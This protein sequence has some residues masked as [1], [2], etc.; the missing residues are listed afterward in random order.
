MMKN[1][2]TMNTTKSVHYSTVHALGV[3]T[4][5]EAEG[6]TEEG[7]SDRTGDGITINIVWQKKNNNNNNC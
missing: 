7:A 5:R 4:T 2:R 3:P 6:D 1:H